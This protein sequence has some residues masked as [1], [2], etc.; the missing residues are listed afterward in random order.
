[1]CF[2]AHPSYSCS[3]SKYLPVFSGFCT[4]NWYLELKSHQLIVDASFACFNVHPL[5]VSC[6][7]PAGAAAATVAAAAVVIALFFEDGLFLFPDVD[8]T[9]GV[10]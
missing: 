7:L 1:M 3:F 8:G 6:E 5:F 2:K 9:A 10:E 4:M